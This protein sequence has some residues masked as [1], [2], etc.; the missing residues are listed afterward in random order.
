LD[1]VERLSAAIL[2]F[3]TFGDD[4]VRVSVEEAVADLADEE[5]AVVLDDMRVVAPQLSDSVVVAGASTTIRSLR[6]AAALWLGDAHDEAYAVLVHGLSLEDAEVLQPETF[7]ALVP[8]AVLEG[9]AEH[10]ASRGDTEVA[11]ILWS[12]AAW[13][14]HDE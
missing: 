2:A 11:T 8:N 9:L 7:A 13:A 10:A 5:L 3:V 4:R 1:Q 12:V 6:I 14:G